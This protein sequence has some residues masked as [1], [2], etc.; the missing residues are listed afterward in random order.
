MKEL[1]EDALEALRSAGWTTEG[2]VLVRVRTFPSFAEALRWVVAVAEVAERLDHHPSVRWDYR[3]VELRLTT[4]DVG[5]R[6]TS[7]DGD[8][9][10]AIADL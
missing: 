10:R 7:L 9:A 6:L 3:R 5:G 1:S 4:H 2:P 8:L